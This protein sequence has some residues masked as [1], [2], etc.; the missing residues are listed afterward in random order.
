MTTATEHSNQ[1]KA[2]FK[3]FRIGVMDGRGIMLR[4]PSFDCG[5]YW[6]FGY[7][8]NRDCH[9]HLDHLDSVD[10]KLANKNLYAQLIGL[11]GDSLTIPR[12]KLWTFCEIVE[13]VYALKQAAEV[14]GRGGSHYNQ[15]PDKDA[16]T[17]PEYVRHIN[18]ELIPMQI[19]SLWVLLSVD[20]LTQ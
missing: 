2:Q 16:L 13:T 20:T 10:S 17:V 1:F 8:G 3:D 9:F 6:G 19:R 7:L 5:W 14:F 12:E 15:N 4:V 11:F 18:D